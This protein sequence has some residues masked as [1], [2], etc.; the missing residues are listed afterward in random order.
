[1]AV[2]SGAD[3]RIH[4]LDFVGKKRL[5]GRTVASGQQTDCRRR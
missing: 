4:I 3:K 1:M 5:I 2:E